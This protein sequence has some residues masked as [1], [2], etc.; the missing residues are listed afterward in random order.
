MPLVDLLYPEDARDL[1]ASLVQMGKDGGFLP[2]WP[3]GPGESG[4]MIGDGA[5]D[6]AR[7]RVREGRA[8][9][10]TRRRG[11]AIAKQ[12]SDDASCRRAGETRSATG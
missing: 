12:T 3:I 7:G 9:V 8:R 1:A 4:G 6:R 2:R 10:G 11:Y 5:H